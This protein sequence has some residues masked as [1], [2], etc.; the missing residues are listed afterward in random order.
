MSFG[1]SVINTGPLK[2]SVIYFSCSLAISSPY[3]GLNSKSTL[4]SFNK[5][6][7][8]LWVIRTNFVFNTLVSFSFNYSENGIKYV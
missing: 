8:S 4:A 5:V 2:C 1:Q 6:I 7:A 3:S